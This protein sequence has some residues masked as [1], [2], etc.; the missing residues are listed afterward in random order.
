MIDEVVRTTYKSKLKKWSNEEV[1]SILLCGGWGP[2]EENAKTYASYLLNGSDKYFP[3]LADS[4]KQMTKERRQDEAFMKTLSLWQSK[5]RNSIEQYGDI[6]V[7]KKNI[8]TALLS[9]NGQIFDPSK[10]EKD[11]STE[12]VKNCSKYIT[13]SYQNELKT[14]TDEY[15]ENDDKDEDAKH[16]LCSLFFAVRW[17][18]AYCDYYKA[19]SYPRSSF[20]NEKAV[21]KK[22]QPNKHIGIPRQFPHNSDDEKVFWRTEWF[23]EYGEHTICCHSYNWF[24][25]YGLLKVLVDKLKEVKEDTTSANIY[26]VTLYVKPEDENNEI[27]AELRNNGAIV[28]K[29][30]A[31]LFDRNTVFSIREWGHIKSLVVL[32]GRGE[33]ID[34]RIFSTDD[35]YTAYFIAH[36]KTLDRVSKLEDE[37]VKLEQRIAELEQNSK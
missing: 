29:I 35:A 10:N 4:Y 28:K 7:L 16:I 30:P 13:F 17:S 22:N 20:I 27:I 3:S 14:L 24:K 32:E 21:T 18:N 34:L 9:S 1:G 19:P 31:D 5:I 6:L 26:S 36:C 2:S 8:K 12:F 23:P 11:S 15:L 25:H 37:K 33:K